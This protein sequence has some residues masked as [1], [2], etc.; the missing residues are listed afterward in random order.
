MDK[1]YLSMHR[2]VFILMANSCYCLARA[3]VET[4]DV[5][6]HV[7]CARQPDIGSFKMMKFLGIPSLVN[8]L[9]TQA[10]WTINNLLL[11]RHSLKVKHILLNW[12]RSIRIYIQNESEKWAVSSRGVAHKHRWRLLSTLISL[13]WT[14]W[15]QQSLTIAQNE[16]LFAISRFI[17]VWQEIFRHSTLIRQF[18]SIYRQV[19]VHT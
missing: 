5:N 2:K 19:F 15:K 8:I 17:S 4:V 10:F 13:T 6:T 16:K 7:C 14:K 18:I 9:G 12:K 3:N 11:P 1:V